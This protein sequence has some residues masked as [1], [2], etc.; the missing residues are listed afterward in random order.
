MSQR[1]PKIR[2]DIRHS[3]S[4]VFYGPP[5]SNDVSVTSHNKRILN[6]PVDLSGWVLGKIYSSGDVKEATQK[7][8]NG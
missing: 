7:P 8:L 4:Q 3:Q 2:K 6:E 1:G 5:A